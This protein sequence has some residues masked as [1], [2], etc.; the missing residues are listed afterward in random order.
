MTPVRADNINGHEIDEHVWGRDMVVY[1]DFNRWDG[2][3]ESA[4]RWAET[5]QEPWRY[6]PP[7]PEPR[8]DDA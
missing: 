5:H 3:Y 1:L 2:S 4:I 7:T 6:I 8:H